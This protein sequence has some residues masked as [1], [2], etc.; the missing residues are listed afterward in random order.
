MCS[1]DI[2]H[3]GEFYT[4]EEYLADRFDTPL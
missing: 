2:P 4:F 3:R 1:A